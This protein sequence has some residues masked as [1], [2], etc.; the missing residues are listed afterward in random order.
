MALKVLV[1]GSTGYIGEAVVEELKN[2]GH[3][4][5]EAGRTS[6]MH[7]VDITQKEDIESLPDVDVVV[8][9]AG[10]GK[11]NGLEKDIPGW[12]E[13]NV[14]GVKNL[15]ERFKDRY[16]VHVSSLAS[17]GLVGSYYRNLEPSPSLPYSRSKRASEVAVEQNFEDYMI[18][19]PADVIDREKPPEML[20][21]LSKIG[22]MPVNQ[23]KTVAIKRDLLAELVAEAVEAQLESPVLAAREYMPEELARETGLNGHPVEVPD[24]LIMF[25]GYLGELLRFSG[26]RVPGLVRAK[27]ITSYQKVLHQEE[28]QKLLEKKS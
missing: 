8:N 11:I 13:V 20:K 16:F 7:E 17:M 24:I 2:R 14:E 28:V 23:K 6:E 15:A 25:L 27:S 1:I 9:T 21:K 18:I 3:E 22:I 10:A 26:F 19:R 12:D 4:V 5:L